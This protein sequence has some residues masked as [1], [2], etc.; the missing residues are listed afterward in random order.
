MAIRGF[1]FDTVE[2]IRNPHVLFAPFLLIYVVVVFMLHKDIMEGDE[3]RYYEFANNLLHGFYSPANE[4]NL[5]N[6]PGYPMLLMPFVAMNLPLIAITLFNA[7]LSY[8]S[9]VLIF[10]SLMN[11]AN[12]RISVLFSTFWGVY[13]NRFPEMPMI[14]TEPLTIFLVSL[15]SFLCIRVFK[16]HSRSVICFAGCVL[17]Y[18]VLTKII[19]G[20]VILLLLMASATLAMVNRGNRNYRSVLLVLLVAFATTTPYLIYTFALTGKVFYWGNSG[21]MSLYWMSSPYK[22]EYGDW[23]SASLSADPKSYSYLTPALEK[24]LKA[25]HQDE[26]DLIFSHKGVQQDSAFKRIAIDNI[27]SHPAKYF[28]NIIQNAGRML[29]DVPYSYTVQSPNTVFKF[30]LVAIVF[31]LALACLVISFANWFGLDFSIRFQLLFVVVYLVL[32]LVVSAMHR[33]FYVII[34]VLLVWF[35]Y[36]FNKAVIVNLKFKDE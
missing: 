28:F 8:L 11:V 9:I 31:S 36:I 3:A 25:N 19:F 14:L 23:K 12:F 4:I 27:K 20:Y 5:W 6:G 2:R 26:Y 32:S 22:N 35:G 33:Q 15:F 17:G 21:G 24:E 1:L 29:I 7:V 10:K 16:N 18:L 34:P 13:Y 30:P